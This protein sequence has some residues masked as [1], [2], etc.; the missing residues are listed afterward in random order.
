MLIRLNRANS[1]L[2][3]KFNAH[4]AL[5]HLAPTFYSSSCS[6]FSLFGVG[7][8]VFNLHVLYLYSFFFM[9][10]YNITAPQFRSSYLS[11]ST[12]FHLV[13][14]TTS[15]SIFLYTWPNPDNHISLAS[16]IFSL[17]FATPA[18]VLISSFLIFS[19]LFIPIIHLNILISVLSSINSLLFIPI[20]GRLGLS[21]R[22]D[23]P[24]SKQLT[25]KHSPPG[26]RVCQDFVESTLPDEREHT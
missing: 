19:I 5:L 13:V 12:H 4:V 8:R 20:I 23:Q 21:A 7:H 6:A 22:N 16:H 3:L 11:V 26:T 14:I 17:R 9:S 18:L 24:T 1:S 2:P 25:T 10:S 15:S